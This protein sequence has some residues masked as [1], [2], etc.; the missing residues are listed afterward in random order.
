MLKERNSQSEKV[1]G[2]EGNDHEGRVET[3]RRRDAINGA[4]V[5]TTD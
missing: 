4:I 2:K 5:E 1:E 3:R